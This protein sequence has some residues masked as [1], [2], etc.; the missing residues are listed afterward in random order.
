MRVNAFLLAAFLI[1]LCAGFSASADGQAAPPSKTGNTLT[2]EA[3][4]NLRTV[5]ELQ[6]SPDGGRL[7]FVVTE[8]AKGTGRLKHIWI[9][10]RQSGVVR[11][12]TFSAKSESVPR[13]SPNGKQLAFLS[14]REEDQQQ[15]FVMRADGGEGRAVT[16][17]KRSVQTFEWSPDGKRIA[18]LAPDAKTEEEEKKEKDKDDARVVDKDDKRTRLWILEVA[19]D[20]A[21]ALT[22]PNWKFDEL[23][24][25]PGGDRV[26]V[27]GTE[28][29]ESD[30]YTEKIYGVQVADGAIKE[31][32]APRGPFGEMR[33]APDGKTIGYVGPR[34]DGPE[35]HDLML[36]PVA[37]HAARNLTGA[38]LDRPVQ[39]YHWEKDGSVVLLAANGF[40]NLLVTYSAD[41][42]RHDLAPAP[43]PAGSMAV[44]GSGEIA[45]VSQGATRPQEV[46]LWDQ[47]SAAKQVTQLNDSWKQFKLSEPEFYKYKS[48]DGTEIE[49]ALL[50]PQR[51]DGKTKLPLIALIHGG[52][53]GRWGDS[54]ETWGQVLATH[55][56]AVFYPNIRG[57][58]GYGQKFVES[59]RG[60]WGGGDFK[61]VMAGVEDLVKR[62]I[63]D[64]EKLAIGGWSYGG[65][66]AEWA[67]TQTNVF[68][69]A[70]S[71]AGMA[72]LISE[73]GTEDHPAGDEW[74]YGVPWEKPEGF[75]NSSPF[76]FLKNAKTPTLV[77][78]GDADPIDPLGQSQ[79]LYRGLKRYGVEAE[80]VV[81]PREPH[82]F[83]EEKHLADRLNRILAWYDKYLKK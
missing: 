52:P 11:Q 68:K 39:D 83:R 31:L 41:G 22:K 57:S 40:S 36:L 9:Y 13:W 30:Q 77:L 51:A 70:V 62:G 15:I 17:G 25:L 34:E 53:T 79:E 23:A 1:V 67:I 49:A 71:G 12:F 29:P 24:W 73:F 82:G 19:T 45:F 48:F 55:G 33:V 50:K 81:Y 7:A 76:V 37:S 63:A 47:K 4:L 65:Y 60:D 46:W 44:T 8:P 75:L 78:Q 18:F 26:T 61:D 21:R 43:G 16:K 5:A 72:N 74:F 14:N 6:F 38:S 35:P 20:E 59:N 69:A 54:I 28:H 56:Y 58:V 80:F 66:M 2:P 27:K 32:V 42:A 10:E 64:P 3:S